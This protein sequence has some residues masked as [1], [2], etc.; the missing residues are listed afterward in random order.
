MPRLEMR[1]RGW[2]RAVPTDNRSSSLAGG[3]STSELQGQ[4]NTPPLSRSPL[5]LS[6]PTPIIACTHLF[7][8]YTDDM[9]RGKQANRGSCFVYY[10]K[11]QTCD[12]K[13][14]PHTSNNTATLM[15][16]M[17][18]SL[19]LPCRGPPEKKDDSNKE[20]N[21]CSARTAVRSKMCRL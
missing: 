3:D 20:P 13:K 4:I 19:T 12:K 2:R 10:Q 15:C 6:P 18:T 7:P 17:G 11:A 21:A 1:P 9:H 8:D 5:C 16:T 14:K